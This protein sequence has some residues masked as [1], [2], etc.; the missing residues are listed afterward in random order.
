MNNKLLSGNREGIY[1]FHCPGCEYSHWFS[2]SGFTPS[3]REEDT[4]P[5]GPKWTWNNDKVKP[6]VRASILVRGQYTCHSFITD[7]KIKFLPDSTHKLSGQTI[8]L[9]DIDS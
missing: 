7:G 2:T 3:Q 5:K 6:T 8:D 4:E 9:P 1:L